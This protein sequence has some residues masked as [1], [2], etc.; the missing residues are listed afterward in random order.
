MPPVVPRL[1]CSFSLS[2]GRGRDYFYRSAIVNLR[3][4]PHAASY[5][6]A[7]DGD[8]DSTRFNTVSGQE[9]SDRLVDERL[10]DSVHSNHANFSANSSASK[11]LRGANVTP[12]R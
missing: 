8:R 5:D 2:S 1:P 12:W 6:L 3:L 7:V 9:I 10:V 4:V 11:E